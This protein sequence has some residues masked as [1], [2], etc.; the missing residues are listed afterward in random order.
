MKIRTGFVSNSSSS[1][2]VCDISG[3]EV[4][5]MDLGLADADMYCCEE[6]HYFLAE[7]LIGNLQENE[8]DDDFRYEVP[9]E[10]CPICAFKYLMESDMVLYI[11]KFY[12]I[13]SNEVFDYMKSINKR[14]RKLRSKYWFEYLE[15]VR[16]VSKLKLD[17]EIKNKFR[18]LD[19]FES[20]L[21]T[22][23]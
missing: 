14:L 16:G 2:F 18:A 8:D 12:N 22:T 13:T 11:E 6:G 7:F 20:Y 23:G 10:H 9:K 4:Q 15:K 19:D 5:G 21:R 3:E 17:E 1:S